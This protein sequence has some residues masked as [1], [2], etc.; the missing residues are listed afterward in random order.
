MASEITPYDLHDFELDEFRIIK[1]AAFWGWQPAA[2]FWR[3]MN[4]SGAE[5]RALQPGHMTVDEWAEE[6]G[7]TKGSLSE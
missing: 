1:G 7:I 5:M 6:N 2:A 4:I 3:G